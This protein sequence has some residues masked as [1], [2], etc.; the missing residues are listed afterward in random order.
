MPPK[1]AFTSAKSDGGDSTLVRPSDWNAYHVT[2]YASGSVTVAT[3]NGS[4]HIQRMTLASAERLTVAGTGRLRI[5][6]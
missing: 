1:H 2:P 5:I 3:G 6:N 4:L